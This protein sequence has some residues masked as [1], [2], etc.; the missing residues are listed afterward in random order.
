[1]R[2]EVTPEKKGASQESAMLNMLA[3]QDFAKKQLRELSVTDFATFRD[4][5]EDEGRS[6]STIRNNL[7]TISAVYE[8][9]IHEKSVDVANPI[10][11]LRRRKRGIPQPNGHRE[12]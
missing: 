1:Y 4:S 8:W 7:N 2:D 12:R 10:A 5:R 9:L 6:A 11:S 3:R